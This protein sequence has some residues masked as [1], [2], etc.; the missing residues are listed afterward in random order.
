MFEEELRELE[1]NGLLRRLLPRNS[2]QGPVITVGGKEYLNF[3]SND[4]L[5]LAGRQ[6]LLRAAGAAGR[7]FGFGA[8][9][10]RLL[11]GG[12]PLHEEL[13]KAVAAFKMTD[14]ALLFNSGYT[15]NTA[16]IAAL[17]AEGSTIFSDEL[18]HASI[19]DGCRLSRAR[20]VIYRHRDA[21]HLEDLM[22]RERTDRKV[23][24]T[25]SVFSMDGDI[26]PLPEIYALCRRHDAVLYLDEAHATGVLGGGRGAL[27][28]FG[29]APH[30]RT[31]QMGTFSKALGSFG[32]FVAGDRDV[33]GWLTNTARGFMFSTALP[34]PVAAA[35]LAS[36]SLLGKRPGLVRRLWANTQKTAEGL[37]EIGYD[38][39]PAETPILTIRRRSQGDVLTLSAFLWGQGIYAPA[40]RPPTVREPRIR[41]TLTAA[42]T[43]G[44]IRALIK[45]MGEYGREAR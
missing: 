37:R 40:I 14:A 44:Q 20:V 17:A 22:R 7:K 15:A 19:I 30:P 31:I 11:A 9:A 45:A 29:L 1:E 26:A 5:G 4:Y 42:H 41:L 8:G 35:S 38:P 10:S 32:A 43:A 6:E 16:S 23:V 24:V 3:A 36:L 13:E 28:H 25:D 2:P 21:G 33:I 27:A 18:N 39:G 12:S 34:A